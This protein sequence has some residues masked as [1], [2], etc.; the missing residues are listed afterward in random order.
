M[1][2]GFSFEQSDLSD[3]EMN[4]LL[5]TTPTQIKKD[6]GQKPPRKPATKQQDARN[7]YWNA[8]R[9]GMYCRVSSKRVYTAQQADAA[10]TEAARDL[11][12]PPLAKYRC[13]DCSGWHLTRRL[14]P[15]A[16]N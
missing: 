3:E 10:I 15:F 13:N 6:D 11:T 12:T 7:E 4:Q 16:D 1:D 2:Y 8:E 14:N 9:E 5:D